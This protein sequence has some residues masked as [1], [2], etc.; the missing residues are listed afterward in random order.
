MNSD[1]DAA[2]KW[3][4]ANGIKTN[5]CL[6]IGSPS[7]ITAAKELSLRIFL[8]NGMV[9]NFS[10]SVKNLGI[11]YKTLH[12]LKHFKNLLPERIEILLVRALVHP[13]NEYCDVVYYNL[14]DHL[15]KRLQWFVCTFCI[16]P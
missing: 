7:H 4:E 10:S 11:V 3:S 9:I 13:I 15:N 1:L 14:A 8:F 2:R 12:S 5:P 6:I 16:R